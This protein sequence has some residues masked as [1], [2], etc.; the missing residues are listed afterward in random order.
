MG[1]NPVS[2]NFRYR[3]MTTEKAC[4]VSTPFAM[5]HD[6][7]TSPSL[8]ILIRGQ[9]PQQLSVTGQIKG[10]VND[11]VI[12]NKKEFV[13]ENSQMVGKTCCPCKTDT[14]KDSLLTAILANQI[15]AEQYTPETHLGSFN[16]NRNAKRFC[17]ASPGLG[18]RE[19]DQEKGRKI[20]KRGKSLLPCSKNKQQTLTR[21]QY[22]VCIL[23]HKC[24]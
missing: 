22:N 24:K 11:R 4:R 18:K 3:Q 21:D 8:R 20:R 19:K 7:S 6:A 9:E 14:G 10:V 2:R 23:L 5:T 1:A 15:N 12:C 13:E 17:P 16:V